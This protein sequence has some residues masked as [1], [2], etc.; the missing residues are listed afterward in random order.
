MFIIIYGIALLVHVSAIPLKVFVFAGQ[1]N[2]E[3]QAEVATINKT[4]KKPL[5]GTLKYLLTDPRTAELFA[6][7]WDN[8]T[9]NWTVLNNVKV[10]F[11]ECSKTQGVNG[12]KIPGVN[13]IDATYG[14]L[15]VGY[16]A[17]GKPNLIGPEYGFGFGMQKSLKSG[18]KILIIKTAWGGKTLAGDFRPPSSTIGPDPYCQG[19]CDP[20][21]IGHFYKVMLQDVANI[22]K[23]GTV[24]K[25]FPSTAGMTPEIAGFGWFQG[26]NDGCNLNETAAY[27]KNMV[28]LIKDLR[29]QWNVPNMAVSIALSGFGGWKP[30]EEPSRKPK[31]CWR[32]GSKINCNCDD[33]H[34]CRRLD[35]MLSQLDAANATRHPELNGHVIAMETRDYWRDPQ[36]SPNHGQGYHFWHNAETYYLIGLAMAKGMLEMMNH[37]KT[38]KMLPSVESSGI[39]LNNTFL[40][41]SKENMAS[42]YSDSEICESDDNFFIN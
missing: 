10:W 5:N 34:G 25:M 21:I 30:N 24:E 16:G 2:M 17:I 11:N 20:T 23:P 14:N 27:E 39:Y 38:M 18:E 33:D 35:I 6:P 19:T 26:W 12:S 28:N 1:S 15:T 8:K 9:N 29:K 36:Y 37:G 32:N 41:S 3:G 40:T 31:G 42:L 13:G 7:T 4:T 22:L